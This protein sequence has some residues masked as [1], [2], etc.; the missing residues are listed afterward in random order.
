MAIVVSEKK[1]NLSQ[2]LPPAYDDVANLSVQL[3]PVHET[4]KKP[5]VAWIGVF[6]KKKSNLH[7][8]K[9]EKTHY[10]FSC[11]HYLPIRLVELYFSDGQQK[12]KIH[13]ISLS[14]TYTTVHTRL[15]KYTP[16]IG[17]N[18]DYCVLQKHR[19]FI[20]NHHIFSRIYTNVIWVMEFLI[21]G[22]KVSLIL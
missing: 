4:K 10:Y 15:P 19:H 2:D 11:D 5:E 18:L 3:E 7:I 16:Q 13:S 12:P 8:Y 17:H 20:K 14:F 1:E 22:Y 9:Y 21:C 6:E